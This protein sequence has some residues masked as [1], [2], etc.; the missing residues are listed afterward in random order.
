MK[1]APK[2]A[3]ASDGSSGSNCPAENIK[4]L[5]DAGFLALANLSLASEEARIQLFG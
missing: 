5:I 1:I 4:E 2:L 3:F